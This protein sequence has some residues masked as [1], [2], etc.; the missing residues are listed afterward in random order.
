M[1]TI[2]ASSIVSAQVLNVD[3]AESQNSYVV[4]TVTKQTDGG[5]KVHDP[6]WTNSA[7]PPALQAGQAVSLIPIKGNDNKVRYQLLPA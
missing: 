1:K 3:F 2:K 5:Y 7:T 6:I 4:N